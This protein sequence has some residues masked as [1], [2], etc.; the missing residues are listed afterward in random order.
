MLVYLLTNDQYNSCKGEYSGKIFYPLK[1]FYENY[2]VSIECS[3]DNYPFSDDLKKCPKIEYHQIQV[4][5]KS[6]F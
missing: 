3:N 6:G 4:D 2:I 1:D 5:T